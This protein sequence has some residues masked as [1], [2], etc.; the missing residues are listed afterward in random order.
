MN[1]YKFVQ[2]FTNGITSYLINKNTENQKLKK[3]EKLKTNLINKIIVIKYGK[4][5]LTDEKYKDRYYYYNKYSINELKE[6][7]KNLKTK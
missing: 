3:D 6:I 4:K 5:A 7:Y 1:R 2:I